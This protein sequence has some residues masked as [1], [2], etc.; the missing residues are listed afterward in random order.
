MMSSPVPQREANKIPWVPSLKI[1]SPV[2][3]FLSTQITFAIAPQCKDAFPISVHY[4]KIFLS[5]PF[6]KDEGYVQLLQSPIYSNH[7][8]WSE[9]VSNQMP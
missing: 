9:V 2:T 1:K 7:S 6:L 4:V 5:T 3:I 8:C